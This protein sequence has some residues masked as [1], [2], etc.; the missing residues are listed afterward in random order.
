MRFDFTEDQ[1]LFQG[2]VRELLAS[3]CPPDAVRAAWDDPKGY[4]P[5]RWHALAEM[6]VV[7]LMIPEE[8]GGMGRQAPRAEL[9]RRA[10]R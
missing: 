7:G 3:E 10:A 8:H 6:G 4:S 1:R 5:A 2:A 9:F